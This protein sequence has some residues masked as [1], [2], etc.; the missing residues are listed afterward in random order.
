[1]ILSW[2]HSLQIWWKLQGYLLHVAEQWYSKFKISIQ[3]PR[4]INTSN[5]NTNCIYAIGQLLLWV[6]AVMLDQYENHIRYSIWFCN[7]MTKN[8]SIA[9]VVHHMQ[10]KACD[11]HS[12]H[13]L[14][15]WFV[16]VQLSSYHTDNNNTKERRWW[17]KN[18]S[19]WSMS[20]RWLLFLEK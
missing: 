8:T 14:H 4:L 15:L 2:H 9:P 3:N 12:L 13:W 10:S 20:L 11:S 16:P 17:E 7:E 19:Q 1:M 5:T 18:A 6:Y